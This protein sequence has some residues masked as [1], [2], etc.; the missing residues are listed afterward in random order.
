MVVNKAEPAVVATGAAL[1]YQQ[2]LQSSLT[3]ARKRQETSLR[4]LVALFGVILLTQLQ[5]NTASNFQSAAQLMCVVGIVVSLFSPWLSKQAD[6]AANA[7]QQPQ[8]NGELLVMLLIGMLMTPAMLM[9]VFAF[10]SPYHWAPVLAMT[11]SFVC[12][13]SISD[14]HPMRMIF[15]ISPA[16]IALVTSL[17]WAG[18]SPDLLLALAMTS[19]VFGT[20][21]WLRQ[22]HRSLITSLVARVNDQMMPIKLERK[23]AAQ[24]REIEELTLANR[25]GWQDMEEPVRTITSLAQQIEAAHSGNPNIARNLVRISKHVSARIHQYCE[26]PGGT[27]DS[28]LPELEWVNVARLFET[29]RL[30]LVAQVQSSGARLHFDPV[31]AD[32]EALPALVERTV[33][34]LIVHCIVDANASSVSVS[35]RFVGQTLSMGIEHDGLQSLPSLSHP[36]LLREGLPRALALASGANLQLGIGHDKGT[37]FTLAFDQWRKYPPRTILHPRSTVTLSNND[38]SGIK[39]RALLID[40][41]PLARMGLAALLERAGYD[42]TIWSGQSTESIESDL[43]EAHIDFIVSDWWLGKSANAIAML[44]WVQQNLP[45]PVPVVIVSGDQ[46]LEDAPAISAQLN[47]IPVRTLAKPVTPKTL[48]RAISD[49]IELD[50]NFDSPG[51]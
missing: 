50:Q 10:P 25:A 34:N 36:D 46:A 13:A 12:L 6:L 23:I 28:P 27:A 30:Q 44:K 40:D 7:V 8:V 39:C 14:A 42:T 11:L 37:G 43:A 15:L 21:M 32:I 41:D 29:L 3:S 5:V 38:D 24:H 2:L 45:A 49:L 4:F 47:Q 31:A 19:A 16:V 35:A 22:R 1:N 26:P 51:P 18:D 48:A 9:T 17:S 33:Q 20:I